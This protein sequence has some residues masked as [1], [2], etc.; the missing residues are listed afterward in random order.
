MLPIDIFKLEAANNVLWVESA[1]SIDDAKLRI[2]EWCAVSSF[3]SRCCSDL[4]YR[5]Q[6]RI[7][8]FEGLASPGPHGEH[9]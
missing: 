9:P 6:G 2:M 7:Q 4:L 8:L 1:R 3:I 5:S